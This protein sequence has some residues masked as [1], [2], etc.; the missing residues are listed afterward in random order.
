MHKVAVLYD[1][2]AHRGLA[3]D[4]AASHTFMLT[5]PVAPVVAHAKTHTLSLA[6]ATVKE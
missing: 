4:V 3:S 5:V 6:D 1:P 2:V